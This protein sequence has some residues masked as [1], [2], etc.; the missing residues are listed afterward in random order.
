LLA[1]AAPA[2]AELAVLDTGRVLKVSAWRDEGGLRVLVLA[3]GGEVALARE[4]IRQ[5][6]PDEIGNAGEAP[7]P[8]AS[9]AEP[10][11]LP[12]LAVAIARRHGVDPRLVLAVIA[13][14]SAFQPGAV[15]P[16]GAQGLMQL[17]PGTAAELGV[18]DAFD[19]EQNLDGGVRHLRE[20][21]GRY[22]GDFEQTLAAYNA[23]AGAVER[24]GGVPPWRETRDYV[25]AVLER[26]RS[27]E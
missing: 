5:L 11:P 12:R 15:S 18:T 14:E 21:L 6:L 3:G 22:Q 8:A 10:E 24:H 27:S 1:L 13:V 19:P 23:G 16:K 17:M 25:A 2:A 4:R 26:Y 9:P 20:L 7:P